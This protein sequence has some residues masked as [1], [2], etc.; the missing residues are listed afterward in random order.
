MGVIGW[1]VRIILLLIV[2]R[3]V[4][5]FAK[6]LLQGLTGDEGRR[7][8]VSGGSPAKGTSGVALV[9]DPVCGTYVVPKTSLQGRSGGTTYYFCSDACRARFE[10]QRSTPRSA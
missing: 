1:A 2:L 6:G 9:Q 7:R 4:L 5:R 10:Q 3:L 8:P